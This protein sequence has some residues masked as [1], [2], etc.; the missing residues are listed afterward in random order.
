MTPEKLAERGIKVKPLVRTENRYTFLHFARKCA[1]WPNPR[2]FT[3]AVLDT[4]TRP[5]ARS[6]RRVERGHIPASA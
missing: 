6:G 5:R 4:A 2:F 1:G 3:V